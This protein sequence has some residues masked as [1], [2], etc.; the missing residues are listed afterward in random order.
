MPYLIVLWLLLSNYPSFAKTQT[1]HSS[2]INQLIRTAVTQHAAGHPVEALTTL[3]QAKALV[4]QHGNTEQQVLVSSYLGDVL[5]VLQ[6]PEQAR[7]YLEQQLATARTLGQPTVLMHLLNH[8]A[9]VFLVQEQYTK[10]KSLYQEVM[11]L[12]QADGTQY[13][14][15]ADNL[16]QVH[17]E[18][19]DTEAGFETLNQAI[20]LV[21]SKAAVKTTQRL[22]LGELALQLYAAQPQ[23]AI[24]TQA[25]QLLNTA[26]QQAKQDQNKRLMSYAKGFLAQVYQLRQRYPEAQRLLREA[27][28]LAQANADLLYQWQ[29]QQG[30]LLK[31][32]QD[33]SGAARAYQ[34]AFEYLQPLRGELTAGLRH[35]HKVFRQ[36][37]R[38]LYY[39]RA[40]VLLQQANTARPDEKPA[41]LKQARQV[42][43]QL[44]AAELQ[45]YFQDDCV[46]MLQEKVTG[47]E[48]LDPHTAVLYP[49]LLP[50][51]IE[52][53]LSLPTGIEHRVVPVTLEQLNKTV[54]TFRENLQENASRRFIVQAKQ[55][56][57]WFIA[58]IQA[59]LTKF[60]TLVIVPDGPLR[61]IPFAAFYDIQTRQFLLEQLAL[62]IT[63][64][65]QL[66]DPRPLPR[67]NT[68]ILLNGLS[69]TVQN[70]PPLPYVEEELANIRAFFEHEQVLL[71]QAFSLNRISQTLQTI[72]YL[73]VHIA[74]H[75]QFDRNPNNTFLLA[76]DGK[77][78]MDR[79]EQLLSFSQF[80][81]DEPV[82]LLTLSACK[83][84]EGDERAALGL[85]GLAIKT[86]VRS[87]LASLWAVNDEST[88]QLVSK[89]YQQ[90]SNSKLTK[91]QALQR[92]QQKLLEQKDFRHPI[93]W[94]AFLLIGNWL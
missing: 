18:L 59:E 13:L 31:A 49:F 30:R 74:S 16:I 11:T 37:I 12:A 43:E 24:L 19:G 39:E 52:L 88:S 28:F 6:Q 38:P 83:T 79:L 4:D 78:T 34:T 75:G 1:E 8:L 90:L 69:E 89:F 50:E 42:I 73:I 29:W 93:Y 58:P 85:A 47:L 84:A 72:P 36:R 45:D 32:Q 53:L 35:S 67:K 64:G 51:R 71:N 80:R 20:S 21:H 23:P 56:Y 2:D 48:Q 82:E 60:N 87:A 62:A 9:N 22:R 17:L 46:V 81:E 70:F 15:T 26:W 65:M 86:G 77:M 33:W 41:L 61:T 27:I 7:A 14:Q 55:L 44:K 57:Q 66:T 5:L 92:A 54:E 25:Y 68:S 76:Y 40:D 63:P 91:A 3:K 10:A 94:A